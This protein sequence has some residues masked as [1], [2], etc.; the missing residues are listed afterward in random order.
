MTRDEAW[1][2]FKAAALAAVD[3][4]G[5]ASLETLAKDLL[6]DQGCTKDDKGVW[7]TPEGESLDTKSA[8]V[9]FVFLC[10]PIRLRGGVR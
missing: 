6:L 2:K 1:T 9:A 5:Y 8:A 3:D 7:L 10:D 4:A